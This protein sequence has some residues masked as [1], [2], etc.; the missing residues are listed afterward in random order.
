MRTTTLIL[1]LT[2]TLASMTLACGDKDGGTDEGTI[3]TDTGGSTDS[4]DI[5]D[6]DTDT[7]GDPGVD[8]DGDGYNADEDCDDT[9]PDVSP[10]Q[11]ESCDGKDNDCDGEVDEDD[12][13]NASTWYQDS[14]GDG[15]GGDNTT[16]ACE[17]PE[18]YVEDGGDCDDGDAAYNPGADEDDCTDPNDYNC[19]GSVGYA[20]ADGDG[21][22]AC[23]ECD[24][25]E[26]AVNPDATEVCDDIDN[27]CDGTIDIG[28][29]DGSTWYADTDGDGYGDP[30]AP[31]DACEAPFGYVANSDDCDDTN[32]AINPA[33]TEVCNGFDDDCDALVDDRDDSLDLS[34]ASTWYADDDADTFGDPDDSVRSCETPRGYVADD[35][36]CDDSNTAVNPDAT[37]VCN[38][39]DDDCDTLVDDA[40]D[41]VDLST[42]GT[43]YADSD[44]DLYG[45]P[46]VSVTACD[47]PDG[48][49]ED[50][51][52]CDDDAT[53]VNPGASEVCN[54]IDDDCDTLVDDDD[55]SVDL[56]TGSTF[57]ADSDSD[58]YGD[59]DRSVSACEQP[60]GYVEDD[61]DC[62]DRRA[63]V[64]PAADEI[65][66]GYDDDC[67]T[68]VDDDD[69]DADLGTGGTYYADTDSDDYGDPDVS[70]TACEQPDGF[71]EDNTDCD[72]DRALTNPG[73][74][75]YCNDINDDCD[76]ETD[77]DAVD[78]G[79][80]AD[81][82]DADG[83][84]AEGT[85]SWQC[86]GADNELDCNDD[87]GGEPVVV[88][89]ATGSSSGDG[90]M[91]SPLDSIQ[92]GIDLANECVVVHAG[93]YYE[94][95]DYSG[96]DISV[97]ALD[98]PEET[99]IDASEASGPVVTFMTSESASALL[100]GFTL[101]GGD[102][103]EESTSESYSCTSVTTCTNYYY[104]YSGGGIYINSADPMIED[105]VVENNSL[106]PYSE[107]SSGDDTYYTSSYGGGVAVIDGNPTFMGVDVTDNSAD[108]G[109]GFYID[110]SSLV[111][112]EQGWVAGNEA[113]D[114][115]GFQVDAGELI[116]ANV[117][118]LW[119]TA[120]DDAGGM[121]VASGTVSAMNITSAGDDG[122][123]AGGIF[124]SGTADVTLMNSI[125]AYSPTGAGLVADSS[126]TFDG[127]YN[128]V[129]GNAGG[130][131]S[132]ITDPTGIGGNISSMPDFIALSDDGDWTNDDI[133]LDE[134][135]P[136]IDAGNPDTAYNDAD[137]SRNDQGA[138]GG[139]SSSWA[140]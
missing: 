105:C 126:A 50:N 125:I 58:L 107:V 85:M 75:E 120:D 16:T 11:K 33:A 65:C 64:N 84:G 134:G 60:D 119:N 66:N 67:D 106:P 12:S 45:D 19:D 129:Y 104:S 27:D 56:S 22:A 25:S 68:L 112:F 39:I 132:G 70:V 36:D 88:D 73:A 81:D 101:T 35:S 47:Q 17:P 138:F 46:D 51:N 1:T 93:T 15:Y 80:Y 139:P 79:W 6:T 96:K 42:G 113:T 29:A 52:D 21:W 20:D 82:N 14:D 124:A 57:Y 48:Y 118:M 32:R 115:A 49:V 9:D 31:V 26:A 59:P 133:S 72:D 128:N 74:D 87:D 136:S 98:G 90:S 30:D 76:S 94:A 91:D 18:G 61:N 116:A 95:I 110:E 44:S 43:Y 100:S 3:D 37:E 23:E 83:Y 114:G 63:T 4:T 122:A 121:L 131:Y 137:G 92:D 54:D 111:E 40:D 62:D 108:Q 71:V 103:Y 24:D 135:S 7:D 13:Y 109:G 53:A 55:D 8:A 97:T 38:D 140:D 102:G 123:T 69:P 41:S 78:G 89:I 117:A 2:A 5:T 127:T 28:A 86:D 99:I 77:E 34:T 10:G 130:E